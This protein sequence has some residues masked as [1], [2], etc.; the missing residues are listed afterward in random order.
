MGAYSPS[1]SP[2]LLYDSPFSTAV[3]THAPVNRWVWPLTCF[4]TQTRLRI[5]LLYL[6]R[7]IGHGLG[8][9]VGLQMQTVYLYLYFPYFS[10][11]PVLFWLL[12]E[13]D[14]ACW[15]VTVYT[16]TMLKMRWQQPGTTPLLQYVCQCL[17]VPYSNNTTSMC[18]HILQYT[19]EETP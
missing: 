17:S 2:E 8:C 3:V 14:G 7:W 19:Q 16:H 4:Y 11:C 18:Q 12:D 1:T 15:V 6:S 10:I 9:L 13:S 5:P